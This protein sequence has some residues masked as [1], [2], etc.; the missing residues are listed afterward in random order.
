MRMN[1]NRTKS[2]LKGVYPPTQATAKSGDNA[3]RQRKKMYKPSV[4]KKR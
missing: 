2:P 4:Q 3:A 1:N